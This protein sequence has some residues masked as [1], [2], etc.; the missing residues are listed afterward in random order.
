M[1]RSQYTLTEAD[2]D[3]F[4]IIFKKLNIPLVPINYSKENKLKIKEVKKVSSSIKRLE[5]STILSMQNFTAFRDWVFETLDG[6]EGLMGIKSIEPK[7]SNSNPPHNL[8]SS[9]SRKKGSE[10]EFKDHHQR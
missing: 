7:I 4:D 2:Y 3:D 1:N 6:I 9:S 8:E 5:S 10:D